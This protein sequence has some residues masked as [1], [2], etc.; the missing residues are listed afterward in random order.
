MKAKVNTKCHV[1]FSLGRRRLDG[2]LKCHLFIFRIGPGVGVGVGADQEPG[3]GFGVG[4][5]P[6]RLRA[7]LITS[8]WNRLLLR[9]SLYLCHSFG[10][11]FYYLS[12]TSLR[13]QLRSQWSD[14]HFSP[15]LNYFLN[16]ETASK[17]QQARFRCQRVTSAWQT[18]ARPDPLRT[19]FPSLKPD[20]SIS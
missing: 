9:S 15:V 5:A 13:L 19:K 10:L 20:L 17:F 1:S 8:P 11:S 16:D 4:T 6:P 3:V 14:F 18:A 2:L 12:L 7:P